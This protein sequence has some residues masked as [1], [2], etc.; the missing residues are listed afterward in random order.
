MQKDALIEILNNLGEYWII[1][2][3]FYELFGEPVLYWF[4]KVYYDNSICHNAVI[5]HC[6]NNPSH[7]M[8][9]LDNRRIFLLDRYIDFFYLH[10]SDLNKLDNN[11][12]VNFDIDSFNKKYPDGI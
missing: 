1:S 6:I 9:D 5:E 10:P 7:I 4:S 12:L 8:I 2:K 3:C 11:T